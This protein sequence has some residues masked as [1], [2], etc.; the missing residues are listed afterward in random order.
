MFTRGNGRIGRL[1]DVGGRDGSGK[2]PNPHYSV[3]REKALYRARGE[4]DSESSLMGSRLAPYWM[5][6]NREVRAQ[7]EWT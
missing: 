2:G 5:M 6:G 7:S 3:R 1:G 4:V